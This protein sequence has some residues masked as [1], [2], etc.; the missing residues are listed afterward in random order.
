LD[1]TT[2]TAWPAAALPPRELGDGG[3]GALENEAR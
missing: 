1:V 2:E 3:A